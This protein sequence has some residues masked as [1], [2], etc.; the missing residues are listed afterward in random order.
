MDGNRG[1]VFEGVTA[2]EIEA[3]RR[4]TVAGLRPVTVVDEWVTDKLSRDK[5]SWWTVPRDRW[6]P[7]DD[8]A[9][10]EAAKLPQLKY[11]FYTVSGR[12]RRAAW[13]MGHPVPK[14]D[15]DDVEQ[16][17]KDWDKLHAGTAG[18]GEVVVRTA[19]NPRTLRDEFAAAALPAFIAIVQNTGTRLTPDECYEKA[20]RHAYASAD[21]MIRERAKPPAAV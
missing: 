11:H 5:G 1:D 7:E 17:R 18:A 19:Y 16:I 20:A 21:A 10:V 2:D 14:A 8:A 6:T 9:A 13:T 3:M 15:P 4:A 12:P